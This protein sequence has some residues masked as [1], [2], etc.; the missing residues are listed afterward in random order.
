MFKVKMV[1]LNNFVH[2]LHIDNVQKATTDRSIVQ[3]PKT[4][5]VH[6]LQSIC[7]I[8]TVN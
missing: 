7:K 3:F 1:F 6:K 5:L 4:V 8:F 2:I